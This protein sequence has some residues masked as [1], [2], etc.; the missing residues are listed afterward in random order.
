MYSCFQVGPF[1][2]FF[3][4]CKIFRKRAEGS[5]SFCILKNS[6]LVSFFLASTAIDI[7][8]FALMDFFG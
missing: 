5:R 6:H 1:V 4:L 7:L 8:Q 3:F 2:E